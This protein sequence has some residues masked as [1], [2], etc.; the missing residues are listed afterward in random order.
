M[1]DLRV[2]LPTTPMTSV[3]PPVSSPPRRT[4]AP[5]MS[6]APTEPLVCEPETPNASYAGTAYGESTMEPVATPFPATR[7][8][9]RPAVTNREGAPLNT[10]AQRTSARDGIAPYAEAGSTGDYSLYAGAAAIKGRDSQTGIE[11]EVYSASVQIGAQTEAQVAMARIGWSSDTG[12][13]NATMDVMTAAA[14]AGIHN[15]DG[16]TGVNARAMATA[17]GVEGTLSTGATGVTLGASIGVG[18]GASVG[19]RDADNDGYGELAIRL[20][21]KLAFGGTIGVQIEDPRGWGVWSTVGSTVSSAWN[22]IT[23]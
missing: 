10:N 12:A 1:S 3:T 21:G 6:S 19:T 16:S 18:A 22:W 2:C 8:A 4:E 14:G 5:Q 23:E 17:V 15:L 7:A 11:A 20:E 13:N 9:A